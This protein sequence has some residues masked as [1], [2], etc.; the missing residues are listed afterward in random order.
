M[1]GKRVTSLLSI[2]LASAL[3]PLA[4]AAFA[5]DAARSSHTA[6][7]HQSQSATQSQSQ[8]Q[9]FTG[10]ITKSNG[11]Y[12][13]QDEATN[14]TYYLDDSRTAQKYEGKNVKVIGTLDAQNRT[15]H[16][17]KIEAA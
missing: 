13:L 15:I 11:K 5:Q 12:A 8:E 6:V 4:A 2:L 3:L 10:K 17:E 9:T 14:T 1:K 7:I 16:V